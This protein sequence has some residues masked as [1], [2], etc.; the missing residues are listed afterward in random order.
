M[1]ISQSDGYALL[2]DNQIAESQE[3]FLKGRTQMEIIK[4]KHG[5]S[6]KEKITL[7]NGKLKTETFRRKTD[8]IRWKQDSESIKRR[9]PLSLIRPVF[10]MTFHE[11]FIKWMSLKIHNKRDSKTEYQYSQYY[12]KHFQNRFGHKLVT[13]FGTGDG[14]IL[15]KE[16]LQVGLKPITV[17][18]I[19]TLAKQ[20]FNFAVA[21]DFIAKSPF[22]NVKQLAEPQRSYDYL[23]KEE[24]KFLLM[25]N[26]FKP[27]YPILVLALNTGMRLGEILGL[28]WDCVSFETNQILVKRTLSRKILSERTKTKLIRQIPMND[29][30][31]N[32]IFELFKTQKS[33]RFVLT[34]ENGEPLSTMH[35]S[36]RKFKAA[37]VHAQ[38]KRIRFHDLRHTYASQ[39]MMSGGNQFDLQK[40]LGHTKAEQTAMYTHLSP[41]HL[42]NAVK[43]VNFE[44][45]GQERKTGEN[46]ILNSNG[47]QIAL[48]TK[49]RII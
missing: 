18:N 26:Q 7:P 27:I 6:Y 13:S 43:I 22:K 41:T 42:M 34:R 28:C 36:D 32:L 38:V 49:L 29:A 4:R 5:L 1:A 2:F 47:P 24:I 40:I 19:L 21:E 31:K 12:K 8:A 48:E 16:L 9:D 10:K 15:I 20:I 3:C 11:L 23:F 46:S 33:S 25:A 17:N 30:V 37:L 14:E 45:T 35:F 39:F 44:A